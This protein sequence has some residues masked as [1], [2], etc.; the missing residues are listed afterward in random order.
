MLI[1]LVRVIVYM[2]VWSILKV[3][4]CG[5]GFELRTIEDLQVTGS[6]PPPNFNSYPFY[7]IIPV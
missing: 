6:H 1:S 5:V 7:A 4:I 2:S 3:L